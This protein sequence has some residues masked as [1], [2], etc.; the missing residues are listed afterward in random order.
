[1]LNL[2]Y[3][4]LAPPYR[5]AAA[6]PLSADVPSV[7]ACV[8]GSVGREPAPLPPCRVPLPCR[9]ARSQNAE[10]ALLVAIVRARPPVVEALCHEVG[11]EARI[12]RRRL[13][14]VKALPQPL[15]ARLLASDEARQ[16]AADALVGGGD[17]E[18][19]LLLVS[20]RLP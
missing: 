19:K 20:A 7:C 8:W 2:C 1:M 14:R 18:Q 6:V 3:L 10:A 13:L 15:E 12:L 9:R 4:Y 17:G 11:G 16:V 5:L